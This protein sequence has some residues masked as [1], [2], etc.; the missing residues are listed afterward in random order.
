MDIGILEIKRQFCPLNTRRR[1]APTEKGCIE[2][3]VASK[4]FGI[5]GNRP[6]QISVPPK[7]MIGF[8]LFFICE[9]P[10]NEWKE[11]KCPYSLFTTKQVAPS[12]RNTIDEFAILGEDVALVAYSLMRWYGSVEVFNVL[13]SEWTFNLAKSCLESKGTFSRL[14]ID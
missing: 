10:E 12:Q 7:D 3:E 11:L 8:V 5:L 6:C 4:L 1:K 9:C 13:R 14:M 2:N